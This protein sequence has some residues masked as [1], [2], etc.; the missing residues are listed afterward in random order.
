MLQSILQ[1]NHS[2]SRVVCYLR[3]SVEFIPKQNTHVT[4]CFALRKVIM[5]ECAL[6][7]K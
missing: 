5:I 7:E 3:P 2:I 1:Y 4:P 6:E